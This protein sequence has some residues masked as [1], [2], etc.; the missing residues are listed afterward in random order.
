MLVIASMAIAFIGCQKDEATPDGP[1]ITAPV[2]IN[3]QVGGTS[4]D[5]TFDIKIPGGFKSYEVSATGGT[6]AKKSEPA[7]GAK[8]GAIVVTYTADQGVGAGTVTIAVTDSNN[9]IETE[10]AAV[11]KT[12]LPVPQVIVVNGGI[13][14]NQ[15]WRADKIYELAGRVI[16]LSGVTLT[17]QPGTIIKGRDGQGVSASALM[18]ARG[19]KIHAVGTAEKPIIMTSV[20]DDIMPGEVAGSLTENDKGKWGGLVILGKA[21]ISFSGATEA[22]IEGVPAGEPL[23]L[24]GG[25]VADDNSGEIQFVSIRHG[26]T[27]LSGGNEINGLT[28][29][30]VGSGTTISDIEIFANVDDGVEFFG[31]SVNVSNILVSY[32]GDDGVDIDQ[33]YSGTINGFM[34]IH[35][36]NTTDKG[37]E[38]DGPEG[39][40]HATGKFILKNGTVK[41]SGNVANP[42]DFKSKA[43][44]TIENVIFTGYEAGKKLMIA[45][46]YDGACAPTSNAYK[47]LVDGN[48]VFTNVKFTGSTVDVYASSGTCDTTTDDA[49]AAGLVVSSDTATG[50]PAASTWSW[51]VSAARSLM[52]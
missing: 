6:T 52:N 29:G 35:G 12:A 30:G 19:G 32:Q 51:T 37:L 13:S 26:G 46:S 11:N 31:G 38:I 17:I 50:A 34:V 9:K 20:L 21:P 44:G 45:A 43:Q 3:A 40:A 1:V 7:V 4:S 18:V 5:V 15:T 48:L 16:V 28:L 2:L 24:Y 8:N 41:G 36:G 25:N 42:A 49:T 47:N 27:E 23:G 33:A 39:T 10:T 14:E 22:Q